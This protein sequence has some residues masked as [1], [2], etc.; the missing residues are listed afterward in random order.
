MPGGYSPDDRSDKESTSEAAIRPQRAATVLTDPLNSDVADTSLPPLIGRD[1]SQT[2]LI[3]TITDSPYAVVFLS[4]PH[5]AGKTLLLHHMLADLPDGVTTCYVTCRRQDSEYGILRLFHQVL[6]GT[7]L[8]PGYHT[9]RLERAVTAAVADQRRAP[10]LVCDDLEFL[11]QSGGLDLLYFLSRVETPIRLVLASANLPDPQLA[12][13]ARTYSSLQ[14]YHVSLDPYTVD[15]AVAILRGRTEQA[16]GAP[17]PADVARNLASTTTN[18]RVALH[19]IARACEATDDD[20]SLA[21]A[22]FCQFQQDAVDRYRRDLLDP[23]TVHHHLLLEAVR[24]AVAVDSDAYTGDI[25]DRYQHL[26]QFHGERVLTPR[27]TSTFLKHLELLNLIDV[28]YH[29]G[30]ATGK[31]RSVELVSIEDL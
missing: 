12:L 30:G 1:I 21:T 14:P 16:V 29:R 6:T 20:E 31:T 4:G 28:T 18:I 27:R 15:H 13:G 23:F 11:L 17:L 22:R 24:D 10:V 9:G 5:G 2:T 3:E 7:D 25:Y 26:C 19:W 8:G